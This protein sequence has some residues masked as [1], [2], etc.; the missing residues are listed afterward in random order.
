M[1]SAMFLDRFLYLALLEALELQAC[2]RPKEPTMICPFWYAH[3]SVPV[4]YSLTAVHT[5]TT[6]LPLAMVVPLCMI[7]SP[8][9]H[10]PR[11]I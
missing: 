1:N 9:R 8:R 6:S 4:D 3:L 7:S 10:H 5:R 11:S 2:M